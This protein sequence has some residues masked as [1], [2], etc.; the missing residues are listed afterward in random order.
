M[1]LGQIFLF[2]S[3]E[4]KLMLGVEVSINVCSNKKVIFLQ[5][6]SFHSTAANGKKT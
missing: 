1:Q 2:Q 3:A 6:Q 5:V 4:C